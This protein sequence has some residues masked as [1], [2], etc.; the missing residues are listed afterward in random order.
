M[1]IRC[2]VLAVVPE[3]FIATILLSYQKLRTRSKEW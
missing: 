1:M 3:K 2:R